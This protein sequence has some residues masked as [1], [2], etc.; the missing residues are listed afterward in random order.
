MSKELEMSFRRLKIISKVLYNNKTKISY[1]EM[2][3]T[4]GQ[5]NGSI[6][7]KAEHNGDYCFQRQEQF[8][9][10]LSY[11]N[12][13]EPAGYGNRKEVSKTKQ[14]YGNVVSID[15]IHINIKKN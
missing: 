7:F 11:D 8:E 10:L 9:Y 15:E 14:A 6:R 2:G 1:L 12:S 3:T 4:E 13:R 5:T